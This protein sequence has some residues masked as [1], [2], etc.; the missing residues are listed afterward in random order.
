MSLPGL[1]DADS[2]TVSPFAMLDPVVGSRRR[3]WPTRL[4]GSLSPASSTCQISGFRGPL[5]AA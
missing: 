1:L 2:D 3:Q 4:G 5:A